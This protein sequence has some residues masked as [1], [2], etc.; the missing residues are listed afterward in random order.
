[1]FSFLMRRPRGKRLELDQIQA[2][3]F[4]LDGTLID[5]DMNRFVPRYLLGVTGQMPDQVDAELATRA[6]HQA[7]AAM[8]AN[9]DPEKTL[10]C[11]LLDVLHSE[12]S[13][14][15]DAYMASLER[16]CRNELDSLAHMVT[17]HPLARRLVE[18]SRNRGWQVVLA[19]NP[20]FPRAVI[21]ARIAWGALDGRAFHHVTDYETA[22][23]CKPNPAFFEE[24]L[25]RLQIPAHACLMV[26]NDTLHDLAACQVGMQTC[27]LTP[28]SIRRPGSRY[29]PDWQGDHAELLA[30]LA[31][32]GCETGARAG[33]PIDMRGGI[34]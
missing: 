23:F 24:I 29:T 14:A 4:D 25:E 15:P 2:V 28:W 18:A 17:G 20:I 9:T 11:I 19:T 31:T 6:L 13:L 3:L 27:L 34:S 12:L 21:D 33:C 7:V 30:M 22:H 16:F 5:V 10:E 32:E 8:F 26:G 1:M